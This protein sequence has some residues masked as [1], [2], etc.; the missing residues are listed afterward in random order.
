MH[1]GQAVKGRNLQDSRRKA[2]LLYREGR[3]S[4]DHLDARDLVPA[5]P[6]GTSGC[7]GGGEAPSH[8]ERPRKGG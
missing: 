5:E 7:S 3:A 1:M 2:L 8:P 6:R 4:Q